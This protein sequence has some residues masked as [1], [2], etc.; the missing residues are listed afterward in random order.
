MSNLIPAI[1]ELLA[2][3]IRYCEL[4]SGLKLRAYQEGPA[5]AIVDSVVQGMG[6]SFVV[7]F[8]R[9]SGKNELQ[10]HIESYLL[11]VFSETD[12]EIV[13]VSPTWK[14]QSLNAMRRLERVISRNLISG[15]APWIKEQGYIFKV[16]G[17]R[18]YFLS[19]S[20]TANIVG[21]TANLLL[22]VDEAQDITIEKYDKEINPMAASTNATRVFWGTAWTSR[23]LLAREKRVAEQLELK[24]GIKRVFIQDA[25]QVEAEVP[26]YG[27]FV[28][29]EIAKL[30]RNHPFV[31]TQYFSEEID[32]EG[33]LFSDDRLQ[34]MQGSHQ[35]EQDPHVGCLYAFTID[36]GGEDESSNLDPAELS[37]QSR[38]STALTIFEIDLESL[39]D[40]LVEA[41]TYKVVM[42]YLWTGAK[43]TTQYARIRKLIELWQPHRVIVDATGIGEGLAS[44]LDKAYPGQ[45]IP[46]KFTQKSKSDLG[47][48][49]LAVIETARYQE[50]A[51]ATGTLAKLQTTFWQQ[52]TS[53]FSEILSGPNRIMRWSVPD[54]T[55]DPETGEQVHDDLL[56]SAAMC[57]LLDQLELGTAESDVIEAQDPLS[58]MSF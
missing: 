12:A 34:L 10:A 42:R 2:S 36:V 47:W 28:A 51:Q 31:K 53:A 57:A 1:K 13:K 16:K 58:N 33:G 40:P 21:A 9:Q 45:V 19:G 8:P 27:K 55:R 17:A 49:F 15:A 24:D 56:I 29:V 18:I 20:P 48:G 30:G 3:V 41:P 43:H 23:T 44:Y 14:P 32:A 39:S 50:H 11:S 7:I 52:C 54:G 25:A 22:H 26:E 5:S 35:A 6:L 46:F 4:G 37:N 38:D